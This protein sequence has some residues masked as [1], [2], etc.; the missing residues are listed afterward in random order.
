LDEENRA[1][2]KKEKENVIFSG[3]RH[4]HASFIYSFDT[5]EEE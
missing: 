1:Q 4:M 3:D 5:M 2:R